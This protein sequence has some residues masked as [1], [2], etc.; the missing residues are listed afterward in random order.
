MHGV[1]HMRGLI[2]RANYLR[3]RPAVTARRCPRAALKHPACGDAADESRLHVCFRQ[4]K[5]SKNVV[6]HLADS[7]GVG[8]NHRIVYRKD[9]GGGP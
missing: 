5:D 9:A 2:V 8:G 4:L 3:G 6:R 1:V 7:R